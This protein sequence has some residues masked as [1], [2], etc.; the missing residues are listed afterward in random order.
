MYTY[1]IYRYSRNFMHSA[2]LRKKD[3]V[4]NF[5]GFKI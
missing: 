1:N 2:D 5:I 3:Y 4:E